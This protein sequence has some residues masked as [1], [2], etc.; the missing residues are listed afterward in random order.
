MKF[1]RTAAMLLACVMALLALSACGAEPVS[2]DEAP[3]EAQTGT[4]T[5]Q[6][7]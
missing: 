4:Q 6:E 3:S 2:G 1:R 7:E 5:P